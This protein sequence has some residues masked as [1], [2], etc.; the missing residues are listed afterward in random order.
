MNHPRLP[1]LLLVFFMLLSCRTSSRAPDLGKI[2]I[3][4]GNNPEGRTPADDSGDD[5][6]TGDSG[7]GNKPTPGDDDQPSSDD[8]SD[9][10]F[11]PEY[12]GD[13]LP[14]CSSGGLKNKDFELKYESQSQSLGRMVLV[15]GN[16]FS[17]KETAS[18]QNDKFYPLCAKVCPLQKA[19]VKNGWGW[20]KGLSSFDCKK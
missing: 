8:R 5:G 20:C 10:N 12:D 15:S 2:P 7:G 1:L 4:E 11:D 6:N 18:T 13:Y 16:G 3:R 17:C 9:V 19:S 14:D